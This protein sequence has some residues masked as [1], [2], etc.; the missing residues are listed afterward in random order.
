MGLLAGAC[1]GIWD[2]GHLGTPVVP[3]G[4]EQDGT[5][6]P[7][8]PPPD[9]AGVLGFGPPT[10]IAE[11]ANPAPDGEPSLRGDMLE[12]Y[13]KSSRTTGSAGM[14]DIWRATRTST[15]AAWSAPQSVSELSTAD[16]ETSPRLSPDGLTI[17]F[18]RNN[19]GASTTMVSTR[20]T[21]TTAW[22]TPTPL[23]EFSSAQGDNQ[24]SSTDPSLL[25]GYLTSERPTKTT[26]ARIYRTTRAST[27]APWG[28]PVQITELAPPAPYKS[29]TP[30]VTSNG[31]A[32]LFASNRAPSQGDFDLWLATR[33]TTADAFGAPFN[34]V[35][36]SDAYA[37]T[38][39]WISDDLKHIVFAS[40]KSGNLELYE[41]SR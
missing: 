37:N 12:I 20:A 27:S 9:A 40:T 39:C 24:F 13:F 6:P 35:E 16:N 7:D 41:T 23:T 3:D 19:T 25:V 22:A 17:W 21:L 28:T 18:Q 15:T 8:M 5:P 4:P 29:W 34:L 38:D 26:P 1:D 32:V 14:S 31:L 2:L 10:L 36:I 33:A 30:W 11:L